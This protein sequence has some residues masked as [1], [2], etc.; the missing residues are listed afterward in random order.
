MSTITPS[1]T[2]APVST[3][4]PTSLRRSTVVSGLVAAVVTTA[5]AAITHA[6][7]VS[8]EIEGEMIPVLG[9]AQMTLIGA[10]I[11]VVLALVL[12]RRAQRPQRTFTVTTWVLTAL[13]CIPSVAMGAGDG[14]GNATAL[15][16]THVVAAA[17]VIPTVARRLADER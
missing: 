16:A 3:S 5:A 2:E 13:S 17:I 10:V 11:G 4:T 8:F 9:F 7:G 1:I 6:A 15:V 14:A 12:R